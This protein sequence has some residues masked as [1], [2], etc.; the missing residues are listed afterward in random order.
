MLRGVGEALDRG[1]VIDVEDAVQMINLVLNGVAFSSTPAIQ[2][3]HNRTLESTNRR[4]KTGDKAGNSTGTA[5]RGSQQ[6]FL[7]V[8]SS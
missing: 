3:P 4:I 2:P 5:K 7:P 1:Y 8:T 6:A